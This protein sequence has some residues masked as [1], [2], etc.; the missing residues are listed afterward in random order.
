[1]EL[2]ELRESG[3]RHGGGVRGRDERGRGRCEGG[4]DVREGGRD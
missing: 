1:M 4:G 2:K 3:G